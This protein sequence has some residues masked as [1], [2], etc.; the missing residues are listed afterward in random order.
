MKAVDQSLPKSQT[1]DLGT[2]WP[3][4]PEAIWTTVPVVN[5]IRLTIE[6]ESRNLSVL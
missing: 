6:A 4:P 5:P 2:F 1:D 3:L